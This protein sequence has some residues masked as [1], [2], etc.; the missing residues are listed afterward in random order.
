[1]E[2][3]RPPL[4]DAEFLLA[5]DA[6][7]GRGPLW[8]AARKAVADSIGLPAEAVHPEDRLADLW[9]MQWVGPDLLDVLFRLERLLGIKIPRTA[10]EPY[11]GSVCY[12]QAG[13]FQE[14]ARGLVRGLSSLPLAEP[15][16]EAERK[17]RSA[18]N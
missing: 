9:R 5:V 13:E 6:E 7:P 10:I 11:I 16:D 14:F 18:E 1:M 2:R 17:W 8:S 4:P 15:A 12:G 3:D